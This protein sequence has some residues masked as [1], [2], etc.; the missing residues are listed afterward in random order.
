M[1]GCNR[2][3]SAATGSGRFLAAG[4]DAQRGAKSFKSHQFPLP[5]AYVRRCSASWAGVQHGRTF[6]RCM[7]YQLPHNLFCTA[8]RSSFEEPQF[9]TAKNLLDVGPISP[10][11]SAAVARKGGSAAT[12][13]QPVPTAPV[14]SHI[15]PN[16]FLKR[17]WFPPLPRRPP[18]LASWFKQFDWKFGKPLAPARRVSHYVLR[19]EFEHCSV[20]AACSRRGAASR[21]R[22]TTSAGSEASRESRDSRR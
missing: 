8:L 13:S 12:G 11:P 9:E 3:L 2:F 7:G 22:A 5:S 17:T 20:T 6:G 16:P 21:G 19:R 15:P 4:F 14:G 1:Q 18:P 10:D